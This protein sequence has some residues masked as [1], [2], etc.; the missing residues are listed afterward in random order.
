MTNPPGTRPQIDP[1]STATLGKATLAALAGAA[2]LLVTVIL[3]AEYG[4]DPLGTGDALGLVVL[5]DPDLADIPLRED[6]LTDQGDAYSVD[7]ASFELE[8]GSFVEYKYRMEEGAA[9]LYSWSSETPV[10]SEMHS[11]PD[12]GPSGTAE[13][14]EV[15]ES[16][17]GR[18]GSYVAPFP[19]VHGWY[20]L[21]EGSAPVTVTIHAA[22][23]FDKAMEYRPSG[24]PT[25]RDITGTPAGN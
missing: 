4:I 22:G 1:P 17:N 14:F 20:W 25:L 6:G 2:L 13:F 3:P 15:E 21:N 24:G 16:T 23:F 12:G 11:E 9:M 7:H 10:R 19:G 8:P 5:S 18:N